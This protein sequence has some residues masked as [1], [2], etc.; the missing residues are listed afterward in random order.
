MA[1]R[2]HGSLQDGRGQGGPVVL[3]VLQRLVLAFATGQSTQRRVTSH[4]RRGHKVR[5]G[6][7]QLWAVMVGVHVVRVGGEAVARSVLVTH[8]RLRMTVVGGVVVGGVLGVG[9][10]GLGLS[11]RSE[12]GYI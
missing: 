1:L 7:T 9:G 4:R 11:V 10:I 12:A 3:D 6:V 5:G 8:R 2:D